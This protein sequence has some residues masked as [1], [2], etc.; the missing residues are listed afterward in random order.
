VAGF[1]FV[2]R[3][4]NCAPIIAV[5]MINANLAQ[6]RKRFVFIAAPWGALVESGVRELIRR[7]PRWVDIPVDSGHV[8]HLDPIAELHSVDNF[9]EPGR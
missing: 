1:C 8:L 4:V 2:P 5:A 6:P 3:R 9:G 7:R